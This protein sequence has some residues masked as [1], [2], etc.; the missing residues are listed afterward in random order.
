VKVK[1]HSRWLY[2]VVVVVLA[3]AAAGLV[4]ADPSSAGNAAKT[5]TVKTVKTLGSTWVAASPKGMTMGHLSPGDR[6]FETSDILRD[7]S[8]KG[9]F[10]GTVT[11]VSPR[12]VSANRA[13]GMV[14]AIYRFADGDLYVDGVVTFSTG[15]GSGV[16]V[17]GTGAYLGARGTLK[18]DETT[19]TLQL[20]P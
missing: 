16:I 12:T 4:R 20:L 15:G 18:S 13:V 19:D 3:G 5:Y 1:R 14:R 10:I 8:V 2:A 9:V 17:G 6:L 7:G 11:V